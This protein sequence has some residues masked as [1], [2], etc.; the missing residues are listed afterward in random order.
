MNR[1]R[2]EALYEQAL[3]VIVGGVNS[4]SRSFRAVGGG[5]PVFMKR[6]QGAYFWDEDGNRYIDYLGA[7]GPIILGHAHPAVTEAIVKTGAEGTLY[8]TPTED[9]DSLLPDAAGGD[10]VLRKM[11]LVNT[12]T[13]A[14]MSP[15]AWPGLIRG[16]TKSSSSPAATT[17]IRIWCWWPQDRARRRS[18]SRTAPALPK[19]IAREV[20]TVP[21]NAWPRLDKPGPVGRRDGGRPGGAHRR[22]LRDRHAR[23]RIPRRGVR[24]A[25]DAGALVI[26]DEVITAFRFHYGG[27]QTLLACLQPDLTALGKIIGGGTAYR[28]IRRPRGIMEQVAPL[29][30][31]YQAGTMAG[32]PLSVAGWNRLPG[33]PGPAGRPTSGWIRRGNGW[34]MPSTT[35]PPNTESPFRS[36]GRAAPLPSISPTNR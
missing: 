32:N 27:A 12:G 33:N 35:W 11:R 19:S 9:G 25:R 2:S 13:E 3:D 6:A 8:G 16:G 15:S 29:G 7:F 31:V 18:A 1:E 28:R 22:Q 23:G 36:T 30:P 21:F 26:Y 34:P 4:P 10:P 20:I 17:A 24:L 5:S 14:V